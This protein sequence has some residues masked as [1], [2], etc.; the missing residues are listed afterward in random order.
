MYRCP[1]CDHADWCLVAADGSACI[2]P[3]I[4]SNKRI[5]D[6]GWLHRLNGATA[7]V[8]AGN[9]ARPPSTPRLSV[10]ALTRLVGRFQR[11]LSAKRV[12]GLAHSLGVT[13]E[14]L[15]RLGIGWSWDHTA[16]AFPMSG[17]DGRVRGIRL[18]TLSGRKFCIPGSTI[19]LFIPRGLR[20]E[21]HLLA[22]EGESDTGA[23]LDFGFSVV[24]RPSCSSGTAL[25]VELVKLHHPSYVTVVADAGEPGQRGAAALASTLAAHVPTV[26]VISPPAGIGDAREWK[27]RG[28]RRHD[29]LAAIE[30]VEP[31][32]LRITTTIRGR[33]RR[34]HRPLATA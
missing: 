12:N 25:L 17:A 32:K 9:T 20:P 28:A 5:G 11:D 34:R 19:G 29:I 15:H 30:A 6:A 18:R 16:F 23:L 27:R 14:S 3:R 8:I 4:E 22:A 33:E 7:R 2:C 13:A 21:D 24:G 26:K 1:I 10:E 31:V